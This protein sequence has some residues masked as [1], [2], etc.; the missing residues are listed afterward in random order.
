MRYSNI[1]SKTSKSVASD[2]DS[3]NAKLLTQAGFITKQIA[4]VYNYLP[5][6]LRVL[7]KIKDIVREEMNN[8]GANEV[9]MPTLTL[10]ESYTASGQDNI[11]ILYHLE[12]HGGSKL[13][14]NQS[15][16]NVV[17]PLINNFVSSYRELPMAVYQIQTKF[18]NEPRAKSGLLRG[19]EFCMKDLYS[20]HTSEED[21]NEYYDKA[22]KAY[23]KIYERLGIGRDMT[24]LT[25]ASGGV[26]SKYSHEFQ[27]LCE[28]GEDTI[29]LCDK[30]KVG[31]NKE[32]INEQSTCPDCKGEL[33]EKK[34]IEVGN[35]FKLMYR[36]T[37]A[38][39][40]NFTD[41][42][43]SSKR[44]PMG[45][46]GIGISRVMGTL[47]EVFNDE[48]GMIWPESVA[49]Y[50]VHLLN[51][52]AN[53]E[54]KNKTEELYKQLLDNK[55]EVLYDDRDL[56]A[57]EKLGDADL[58][59]CPVR[60]VVSKKTLIEDTNKLIS[61]FRFRISFFN[62]SNNSPLYQIF[63]TKR[64]TCYCSL[65]RFVWISITHSL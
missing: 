62:S 61:S 7:E 55:V 41:T 2:A 16:E 46:Y 54:V 15:H 39:K 65:I 11:D 53:E 60:L 23:Y 57:G 20:F 17:T 36:F 33:V 30:C 22:I 47:V 48:R 34:S 31:V 19:R 9:L 24:V 29:F 1:F 18:R 37:D 6:G 63:K 27:T 35:I 26:F 13:V 64:T 12:G 59:G 52:G 45:C 40:F 14:L 5:L 43:G 3:V 58:I 51:L 44:I 21:L 10:E 25:Y 38:F 50:K 28:V 8:L 49:P 32:I 42:D 4:G 56:G